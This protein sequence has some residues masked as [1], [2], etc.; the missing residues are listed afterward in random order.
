MTDETN[1]W[2]RYQKLIVAELERLDRGLNSV[3]LKLDAFGHERME[4]VIKIRVEIATLR[5]HDRMQSSIAGAIFG[6]IAGIMSA[7]ITSYL[8]GAK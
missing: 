6:A 5:E 2:E 3:H 8:H 7:I 1:T 4:E